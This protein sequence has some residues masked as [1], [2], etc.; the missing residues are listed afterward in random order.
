ML[1]PRLASSNVPDLGTAVLEELQEL[2]NEDIEGS[3]EDIRVEG[4]RRILADLLEGPKC[5]LEDGTV[6][7][8]G[9][10]AGNVID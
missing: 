5:T 1:A 6:K 10:S 7:G 8:N 9:S 4:L 3:I 2:R